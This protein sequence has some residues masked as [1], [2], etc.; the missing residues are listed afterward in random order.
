MK[1]RYNILFL[2]AFLSLVLIPI[3]FGQEADE[4]KDNIEYQDVVFLKDGS[5]LRGKMQNWDYGGD[6]VI[7]LLGGQTMTIGDDDILRVRQ[8]LIGVGSAAK[9]KQPF[10]FRESGTYNTFSGT[11]KFGSEFGVGITYSLGVRFNQYLGIGLGFGFEDFEVNWASEMIPAFAEVRGY[12]SKKKITPYY[13]L[14]AGLA[15]PIKNDDYFITETK[16][17]LLLNPEVGYRFGGQDV[18]YYMGFGYRLQK[19]SY[20][21]EFPWEREDDTNLTYRRLELKFGLEF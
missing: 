13:S 8:E 20:L 6:L 17:G 16:P 15:F 5:I 4:K 1:K 10:Q 18:Q 2:T 21:Q 19:A 12:L 9:V 7:T 14:R 3:G 11:M